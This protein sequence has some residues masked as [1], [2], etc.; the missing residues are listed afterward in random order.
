MAGSLPGPSCLLDTGEIIAMFQ[1]ES[2][3]YLDVSSSSA[4]E[5]MDLPDPK[6]FVTYT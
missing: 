6:T 5:V 1:R 2:F 3:S 4:D